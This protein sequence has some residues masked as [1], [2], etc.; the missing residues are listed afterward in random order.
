M[1]ALETIFLLLMLLLA[2]MVHLRYP[3][4]KARRRRVLPV[5]PPPPLHSWRINVHPRFQ[6]GC[7]G[8]LSDAFLLYQAGVREDEEEEQPNFAKS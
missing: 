8:V 4:L 1:A 7:F 5:R 2:T 3:K 6:I